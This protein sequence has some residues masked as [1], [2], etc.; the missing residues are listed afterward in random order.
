MPRGQGKPTGV[1]SGILGSDGLGL[2]AAWAGPAGRGEANA[3]T[4]RLAHG[5]QAVQEVPEAPKVSDG[6]NGMGVPGAPTEAEARAQV[7]RE[8]DA[9]AEAWFAGDASAMTR[10]LHP[11]FVHRLLGVWGTE[12]RLRWDPQGLVRDVVGLQGLMGA[13]TAPQ[14]RPRHQVRVLDV[15]ARSASAVAELAGWVLHLHLARGAGRWSI[16]NALWEMP[17]RT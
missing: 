1:L 3:R 12:A 15:R 11:D 9:F 5:G 6:P 2:P 17:A 10:C 14:G 7:A 16:V 13:K 8:V 4:G